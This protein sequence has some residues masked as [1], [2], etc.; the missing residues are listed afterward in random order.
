MLLAH[1]V[2]ADD[3]AVIIDNH[4]TIATLTD[5]GDHTLRNTMG[6]V[7]IAKL[8]EQLLL[9]VISYHTFVGDGCPEVL[10]TV[11]IYYAGRTFDTHSSINLLHI[12]L[13]ALCLRVIDAEA[14]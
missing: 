5:R 1:D 11:N 13:K 10:M 3:A 4:S 7:S 12:A 2:A 14:C 8:K 6:I 9:H